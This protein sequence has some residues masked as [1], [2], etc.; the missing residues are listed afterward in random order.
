MQQY[1]GLLKQSYKETC[2]N[3]LGI[4]GAWNPLGQAPHWHNMKADLSPVPNGNMSLTSPMI[5]FNAHGRPVMPHPT[6]PLEFGDGSIDGSSEWIALNSFKMLQNTQASHSFYQFQLFPFPSLE[7]WPEKIFTCGPET[8]YLGFVVENKPRKASENTC[9]PVRPSFDL[10]MY[11]SSLW[12]AVH[13]D[14]ILGR[15]KV[16]VPLSNFSLLYSS[17]QA[18]VLLGFMRALHWV[19]NYQSENNI[20]SLW[21]SLQYKLERS[22]RLD[23]MHSGRTATYLIEDQVSAWPVKSLTKP[24]STWKNTA[25]FRF[26]DWHKNGPYL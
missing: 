19:W 15:C 6:H 8:P 7:W 10:Y 24:L 14:A 25:G 13:S 16:S 3:H 22:A 12:L 2:G 26:I 9:N 11:E 21:R 17:P 5:G 1:P 4:H 18:Y 20:M 23:G